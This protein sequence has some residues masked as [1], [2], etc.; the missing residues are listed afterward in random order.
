MHG[1][2]SRWRTSCRRTAHA[3]GSARDQFS[4]IFRALKTAQKSL[5]SFRCGQ[6]R[7]DGSTTPR[8]YLQYLSSCYG[9]PNLKRRGP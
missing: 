2:A 6:V 8:A 3:I 4:Y 9:D 7:S 5:H 1:P